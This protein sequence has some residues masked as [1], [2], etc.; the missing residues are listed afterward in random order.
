MHISEKANL[1]SL[2]PGAM[3][4][5]AQTAGRR[6]RILLGVSAAVSGLYGKESG[7]L[8]IRIWPESVLIVTRNRLL[9]RGG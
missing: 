5:M 7:V 3:V 4:N 1:F 6:G 2:T 9:K 8:T